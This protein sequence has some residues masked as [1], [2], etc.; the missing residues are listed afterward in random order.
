MKP[1]FAKEA[2]IIKFPE[3][4]KKVIELPNVQS[5]PDFLTGVKDL[6]NR[7]DKGEI[8]Q[9]SHDKLYTDLIHRFMK[10]ESFENPWFL[11]EAPAEQ[12]IMGLPQAQRIKA[13][14][15]QISQLPA[16]VSDR[17][18]DKIASAIELAQNTGKDKTPQNKYLKVS[19]A[20]K[21]IDDNDL[22]KYYKTVSKFMIGND[23]TSQEISNIVKSINDNTCI[24]VDQL[25]K[26][27]NTLS[28]IIKKDLQSSTELQK[29]FN[30]ML[31][32]QPEQG[33][34]PGE[35]L[36]ATHSKEL[37]KGSKGDLLII[38]SQT[39]IE[40]KGGVYKGR[41]KDD[42]IKPSPD[43]YNKANTFMK[44]YSKQI[45]IPPSGV[46]YTKLTDAIHNAEI[47]KQIRNQ[48]YKDFQSIIT[49]LFPQNAYTK[50]IIKAVKSN[51]SKKALNFHGMANLDAYF[52]AKQA[53]GGMG[54]LFIDRKGGTTKT[55]YAENLP[56]L[57]K[58]FN[59]SVDT[60]YPIST[61]ERNPFAQMGVVQK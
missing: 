30:D 11:R 15:Q 28:N 40:V 38:D 59:L 37:M 4:E 55:S 25:K 10:K 31:L 6:H 18:I 60:A 9:A 58:G 34:G 54:I 51:D 23:L 1:W 20:V 12:G 45:Q 61:T 46:N 22:K 52:R 7:K 33:I 56:A 42:D 17:I 5:Y 39:P 53:E 16:D 2:D 27:T 41:F 57:L 29:Y 14:S 50:E 24:D 8:S 43:Y 3:P 26:P 36:F 19:R 32:Y 47:N 48:M 44:K 35:I 13:L 21:N 49:D